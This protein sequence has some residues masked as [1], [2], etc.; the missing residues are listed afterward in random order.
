MEDYACGCLVENIEILPAPKER[1]DIAHLAD[2]LLTAVNSAAA[3]V[4]AEGDQ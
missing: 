1:T 2:A 3:P 4:V